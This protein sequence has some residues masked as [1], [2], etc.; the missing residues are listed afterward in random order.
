MPIRFHGNAVL[1]FLRARAAEFLIPPCS[2]RAPFPCSAGSQLGEMRPEGQGASGSGGAGRLSGLSDETLVRVLRHLKPWEAMRARLLSRRWRRPV[3]AAIATAPRLDIRQPCGCRDDGKADQSRAEAFASFVRDLLLRQRLL[4]PLD[5]LRLCWSHPAR[6]GDADKWIAHAV[7]HGAKEIELSGA[8][9][10][11][12]PSPDLLSYV[13]CNYDASIIIIRLRIA[14]F[15]HVR[16]DGAALTQFCS[17]CPSLEELELTDC[18]ILPSREDSIRGPVPSIRSTWM[19]HFTMNKC[20][21]LK[22]L[23]VY[24]PK[25]ES[26]RWSGTFGYVPW[27]ENFG[28]VG[29]ANAPHMY[30]A[31]SDLASCKIKILM[32]SRI[33]LDGVTLSQLC[34]RCSSLEE[35]ELKDCSVEGKEI[36]STCLK[37]LNLVGCKFVVGFSVY[38]PNLVSLR[39][40]RPFGYVPS[41]QNLGH[42]VTATV[43][44]D[45]LCLCN[46]RRWPQKVDQQEKSDVDDD[47]F[48]HAGSKDSDGNS[49]AHS[50]AEES[51]NNNHNDSDDNS[52]YYDSDWSE[53]SD[54]EEDDR[55]ICYSDIAHEQRKQYKYWINGNNHSAGGHRDDCSENSNFGGSGM[56]CSLSNVKTMDLLAHPEEVRLNHLADTNHVLIFICLS[57][58]WMVMI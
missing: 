17:G 54:D 26:F 3:T 34:S 23:M 56:L 2:R 29:T 58:L 8:H 30:P 28:P 24:A 21:I 43:M 4:V 57:L 11:V 51:G 41:I 33:K 10:A 6:D 38:S 20:P 13:N 49:F 36:H 9:H 5:A 42:L 22:G 14:K 46:D 18:L 52:T 47:F 44:L 35:L 45:D 32:F 40:I 1:G 15:I 37:R 31:C 16:L 48:A 19:K 53:P 25:L 27:I 12:Y 50:A 39:C 55:F 7:M